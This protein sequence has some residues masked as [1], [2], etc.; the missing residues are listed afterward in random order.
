MLISVDLFC[1]KVIIKRYNSAFEKL[2]VR[3]RVGVPTPFVCL[4]GAKRIS[5]IWHVNSTKW[6]TTTVT[7]IASWLSI[8]TTKEATLFALDNERKTLHYFFDEGSPWVQSVDWPNFCW[9]HQY[10]YHS[11]WYLSMQL[12]YIYDHTCFALQRQHLAS[13]IGYWPLKFFALFLSKKNC[14]RNEKP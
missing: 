8:L 1:L 10:V 12:C 7:S 5:Y 9:S 14:N 3:F 11:S 4:Q 13:S 6:R 2:E